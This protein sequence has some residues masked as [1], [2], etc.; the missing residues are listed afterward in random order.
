[1][2]LR[3]GS[4]YLIKFLWCSHFQKTYFTCC[5][6]AGFHNP[7][8]WFNWKTLLQTR[9]ENTNT[10]RGNVFLIMNSFRNDKLAW[11]IFKCEPNK[12]PTLGWTCVI[13]ISVAVCETLHSEGLQIRGGSEG[14]QKFLSVTVLTRY[15][16]TANTEQVTAFVT[17]QW[18]TLAF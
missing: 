17:K 4:T 5:L 16:I 1:M 3:M 9:L 14:L 12:C 13:L 10:K 7:C 18:E 2:E 11:Y 15:F 6:S 8:L